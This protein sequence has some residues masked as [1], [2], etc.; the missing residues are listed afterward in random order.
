MIGRALGRLTEAK[1][2]G[3][4]EPLS[5]RHV[6]DGTASRAVGAREG[7]LHHDVRYAQPAAVVDH[8]NRCFKPRLELEAEDRTSSNS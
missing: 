7:R 6:R 3:V 8:H 5:D 2:S 1:P 4:A